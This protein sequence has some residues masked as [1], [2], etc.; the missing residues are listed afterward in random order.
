MRSKEEKK[1]L[2]GRKEKIME[3]L[4]WREKKMRCRIE[5]IARE[6]KRRG[7]RVWM[8]MVG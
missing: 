1:K 4:T 5:E 3:D 8:E 7:N 6:E 2:K